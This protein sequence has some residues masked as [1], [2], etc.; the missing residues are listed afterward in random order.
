M[1]ELLKESTIDKDT[2][3]RTYS[4][5][6]YLICEI[7]YRGGR[8]M[9]VK[10]YQNTVKGRK[11]LDEFS[12]SIKS[13]E[14]VEN[15][16]KLKGK[17]KMSLES[18]VEEVKKNNKFAKETV[19]GGNPATLVGRIA[20]QKSAVE[21]LKQL[22]VQ[23][24]GQLKTRSLFVVATGD[25]APEF[26]V[27][28]QDKA[29]FLY[30]NT[31]DFYNDLANKI[32]PKLYKNPVGSSFV[33][34]VMSRHFEDI[35]RDLDIAS[36]PQIICSQKFNTVIKNKD[37]ILKLTKK[38]I[39]EIVGAEVA[40]LYVFEKLARKAFDEQFQDKIFPVMI[41]SGADTAKAIATGFKTLNPR[42]FTVSAGENGLAS[43]AHKVEDV[44]AKTVTETLTKIK[45]E[46]TKKGK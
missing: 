43:A 27:L 12:S 2:K 45:K 3:L 16:F 42:V 44:D 28:A 10:N 22:Y 41:T 15:Y 17:L 11:Q 46:V 18:V 14:D 5:Q 31:D 39:N 23:Y 7:T 36:Y 4:C 19:E 13:G 21:R 32:D 35:A 34:D 9:I 6:D 1:R 25:K 29:D 30:G 26:A 20:R 8:M 40:A 33:M 24:K 37:D 38:V